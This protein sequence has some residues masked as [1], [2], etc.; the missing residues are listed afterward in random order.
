MAKR[1]KLPAQTVVVVGFL[2]QVLLAL[3][4]AGSFSV[5]FEVMPLVGTRV[6]PVVALCGPPKAEARCSHLN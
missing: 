4:A 3:K 2:L 6:P 5:D 1:P